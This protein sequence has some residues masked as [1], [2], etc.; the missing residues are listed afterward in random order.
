MKTKLYKILIICLSVL[1]SFVF[2]YILVRFSI[3]R[4]DEPDKNK[5][6]ILITAEPI[7]ITSMEDYDAPNE[8]MIYLEEYGYRVN[9]TNPAAIAPYVTTQCVT[10]LE[11]YLDQ[12]FDYYDPDGRNYEAEIEEDSI[13]TNINWPSFYL[14]VHMD[15]KDLRVKC[16]YWNTVYIYDF[17]SELSNDAR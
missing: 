2:L 14:V 1:L 12:Y 3:N 8:D 6:D 5:P 16:V 10:Q 7:P 13:K 9:V 17:F 4:N 11:P 15:D